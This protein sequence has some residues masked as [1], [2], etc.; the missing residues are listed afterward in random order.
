MSTLH[1]TNVGLFSRLLCAAALPEP[2]WG[3]DNMDKGEV[4]FLSKFRFH[5]EKMTLLVSVVAQIA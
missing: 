4:E 1:L 2:G 3:L 5:H